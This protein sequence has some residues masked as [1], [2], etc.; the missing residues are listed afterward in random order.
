[1]ALCDAHLEEAVSG[2]HS[3]VFW[4]ILKQLGI[5]VQTVT[6]LV[7]MGSFCIQPQGLCLDIAGLHP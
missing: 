2:Q 6:F 5:L 7:Y 4:L 1:M 3:F